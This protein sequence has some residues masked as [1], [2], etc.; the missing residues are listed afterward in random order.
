MTRIP[1]I[2]FASHPWDE[3]QW[4][5]RQHILSRLAGMGWPVYY[6]TGCLD[7]WDRHQLD[8]Q[9]ATLFHHNV[10][11]DKVNIVRAGRVFPTWLKSP[12]TTQAAIRFYCRYIRQAAGIRNDNF[13]VANFNPIYWPYVKEL[14]ARYNH[15]HAYDMY[16]MQG[17]WTA[18]N[19][20]FMKQCLNASNLV[21]A[22][23]QHLCD[24]LLEKYHVTAECVEN[25]GDVALFADVNVSEPEDI[26]Q[27]PHPRIGHI[28]SFNRKLDLRVVAAVVRNRPDWHWVFVGRVEHKE[29]LGDTYNAEAYKV[30]CEL[31][32][33]H[34]LGERHRGLIPAYN[35]HF[36]ILTSVI[37]KDSGAW[38]H[39]A[40]PL[41][42]VEYLATGK[43][44]VSSPLRCI[45]DYFSGVIQVAN[46]ASEWEQ[47]IEFALLEPSM[48][49]SHR[50]RTIAQ[51]HSWDARVQ[52]LENH[53]H[54]Y[55]GI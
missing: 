49:L 37:R 6:C 46:S 2:A 43:P 45:N 30:L 21:T 23:S 48:E 11:M 40:F 1:I 7:L 18:N 44:I 34:L 3:L 42:L 47:K 19:E 10:K 14:N 8:W 38:G 4:M 53:Y 36:D 25:G 9:E 51:Q 41:K 22:S 20:L 54:L 5:N 13:I 39:V 55:F 12:I 29:L 27:I 32:N 50:R 17:A 15:F 33:V 52:L 16:W 28:S 26:R 35:H 31:P 24:V